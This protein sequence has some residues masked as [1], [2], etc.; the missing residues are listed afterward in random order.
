MSAFVA[1]EIRHPALLQVADTASDVN[2]RFPFTRPLL[3]RPAADFPRVLGIGISNL[4]TDARQTHYGRNGRRNHQEEAPSTRVL[5][6]QREGFDF[7]MLVSSAQ[8]CARLQC[9]N[10]ALRVSETPIPKKAKRKMQNGEAEGLD[11]EHGSDVN[12]LENGEVNNNQTPKQKKKKKLAEESP[13][14]T[15]EQCNGEQ[16]EPSALTPKKVKKKKRK[17]KTE[18]IEDQG[19]PSL[20]TQVNG[21]KSGKKRKS[22]KKSAN[23]GKD[24]VEA[25]D[26]CEPSPKKRKV[27]SPGRDENESNQE[28]KSEDD[29]ETTLEKQAGA[30][31]NFPISIETINN[32]KA[33]GVTYLFPIQAKTF[34]TV[35]SGKD[36]VVQART[37]TGKT[38]SFAIPVVEML[39]QDKQPPVRGRPPRVLILT[40]TRELAIQIT[41][42]FRS[43]TKKLKICCFYGGTPYQQQVFS[44]K[45]GIDVVIGTPG[46]VRDLIQNYRLDFT[47]LKHVVLDE[48]DMMF[49]MGFAEQ[50]EEILSVRYK[51]D[52]TENP[53][54]LLFSATCPDWLYNVSKKYM[55]KVYEKIDMVGHRSQRAAITVEISLELL[56]S[57][58]PWAR[59]LTHLA[60]E[61]TRAQKSHVLGDI[62][63]VYSGRH[64]KTIVFCDSKLEAHELA[65][66]C[67]SLKQTAKPMHGDLQQREREVILKGFRQGTFEV[68]V[69]TNVAARGLDIPEVDLVVL[70][71][72]PKEADSYVHRSGR[73]GRAG[74]TGICISLYE[75]RDSYCLR[76]VERS[77]G[78]TFKRVGVPS[79]LNVA[80]SSSADAIKSL[81]TVP[82]DVV[83]HFKVYAEELIE[84]KGALN[85]LAAA[86]AHI[87]GATSI[88]QRSLLN[89]EPGFITVVLRSSVAIST[90]SYA[91]RCIKEQMGEE[92]DSKIHRMNMMKDSM[93][94]WNDS[95][96]WE[97]SVATQLPP[98]QP[99]RSDMNGRGS[100][101]FGGGGNDRRNNSR[102]S[103]GRGGFR[104]R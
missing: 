72:A 62:I 26:N 68:L 79:L 5:E 39:N 77:T 96:R 16:D 85:A 54:T 1:P 74:R 27:D 95:R 46:R 38:F 60:I 88:K 19:I 47:T 40:P 57:K 65:T 9:H 93:E 84:K 80:E 69:A 61:C 35:Y 81:E 102:N 45:E 92:I 82:A 13:P 89:M 6:H 94:N 86:L 33:K 56:S 34:H 97:L 11:L 100:R 73:T 104:R 43:I 31:E 64:G 90:I 18:S 103:F 51:S 58:C 42:E 24:V 48:V 44:I 41:N 59:H 99:S 91:W 66:N 101:G 49:D 52:P 70:Y 71:S 8:T 83:E 10:A 3:T 30:F 87:S 50:V 98:L 4:I 55:Q 28:P 29:E 67:G 14:E 36:V 53:Q 23:A 7:W 63:Q 20:D 32:L 25:A 76:N 75:P 2:F 21:E 17:S 12:G 37:G 78:I 22:K 15:A